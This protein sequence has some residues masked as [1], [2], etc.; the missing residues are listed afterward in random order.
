MN[1]GM[2]EQPT[3]GRYLSRTSILSSLHDVMHA[4]IIDANYATASYEDLKT[5]FHQWNASVIAGFPSDRVLASDPPEGRE[6]LCSFLGVP[7]LQISFPHVNRRRN[8]HA[9]LQ[10]QL[11]GGRLFDQFNSLVL[12]FLSMSAVFQFHFLSRFLLT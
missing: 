9:V 2:L 6:I 5:A 1:S 7:I 3:R 4:Q 10:N 11:E 12:R 8:M